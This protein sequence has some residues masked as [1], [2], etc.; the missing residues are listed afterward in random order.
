MVYFDSFGCLAQDFSLQFSLSVL[1]GATLNQLRAQKVNFWECFFFWFELCVYF[2]F[3]H[4]IIE[5]IS[6]RYY[7]GLDVAEMKPLGFCSYRQDEDWYGES[8]RCLPTSEKL[9][10]A[11]LEFFKVSIFLTACSQLGI[12]VNFTSWQN[13]AA[14]GKKYHMFIWKIIEFSSWKMWT[15]K[16]GIDW[17]WDFGTNTINKMTKLTSLIFVA[18]WPCTQYGGA[19]P[20]NRSDSKKYKLI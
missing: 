12:C 5:F 6:K 8:F 16:L 4:L 7:A 10:V 11:N 17:M 18:S 13:Q 3:C 2:V 14:Y 20:R 9:W 15:L 1:N 19:K